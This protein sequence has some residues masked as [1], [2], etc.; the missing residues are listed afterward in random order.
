MSNVVVVVSM[1]INGQGRICPPAVR[2]G[3]ACEYEIGEYIYDSYGCAKK[4]CPRTSRLCQ[5]N[6]RDMFIRER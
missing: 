5:V 2:P 1:S 4:V 3:S 6:R